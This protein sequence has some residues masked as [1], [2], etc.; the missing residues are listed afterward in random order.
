MT[1]PHMKIDGFIAAAESLDQNTVSSLAAFYAID[2][3]FN[4]PFQ[5]V[6]GRQAVQTVYSAMFDQL[7]QPRFSRVCV[8]AAPTDQQVVMGWTFEFALGPD[9]PK[10]RIA[11][12]SL[13]TLNAEGL[14]QTHDDYWD[15]SRLMEALPVVGRLIHWLRQKIGHDGKS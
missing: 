7:F 5:S 2:C 14:I 11:G 15:A 1:N 3:T 12:C 6:Q 13:L 8:L 10:Q 4:D 9:K